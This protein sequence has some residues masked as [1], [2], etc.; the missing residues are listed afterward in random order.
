MLLP[1]LEPATV[2]AV[3]LTHQVEQAK[4]D[5][6]PMPL[7]VHL[8]PLLNNLAAGTE[9]QH[10]SLWPHNTYHTHEPCYASTLTACACL[11]HL[12]Q[13]ARPTFC[14][15]RSAALVFTTV[16]TTPV[17]NGYLWA[18]SLYARPVA[19]KGYLNALKARFS[20]LSAI[21]TVAQSKVQL[22]QALCLHHELR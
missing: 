12:H 13:A 9:Q 6:N 15:K 19:T 8:L 7:P 17:P 2:T 14:A 1:V 4:G 20:P 18:T 16:V 22:C 21:R 11:V 5:K 10:L 3:L